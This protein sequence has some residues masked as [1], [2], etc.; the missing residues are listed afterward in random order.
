MG[1]SCFDVRPIYSKEAMQ[2][3]VEHHY[4]H[5]T[6]GARHC[7]G[8]FD[9]QTLFGCVVYS[10]PASYTLCKGVCGESY[11]N[12]VLE[13][14]RLVVITKEKNAASKLIGGSVRELTRTYTKATKDKTL[15]GVV[16]VSYADCNEHVGHVGYVYQATN[17]LYTGQGSA[18][19]IWVHPETGEII[20]YTRRHIDTKAQSI[21][22]DW[23]DLVKRPQLGKHRYVLFAGTKSF[24]SHAKKNL[25]YKVQSYPKGDSKRHKSLD[26]SKEKLLF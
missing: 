21:G 15:Q 8:L 16:L 12:N 11:K 24:I 25:R 23:N 5:R 4:S 14:S 2:M 17:W 3:V 13:L 19:P 9:K 26:T 22:L 18:E 1:I 20:S 10:Q 6:V 7:F